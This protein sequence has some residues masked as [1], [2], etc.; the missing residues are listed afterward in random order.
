MKYTFVY[1]FIAVAAG[2]SISDLPTCATSCLIT[3]AT[4]VGCGLTDFA[5]ACRKSSE[6]TP[7]LTTCVQ[8]DCPSTE[9]QQKVVSVVSALCSQA[10]VP[11]NA[12]SSSSV[13]SSASSRTTASSTSLTYLPPNLSLS[14]TSVVSVPTATSS[15]SANTGGGSGGSSRSSTGSGAT[16]AGSGGGLGGA[17][18]SAGGSCVAATVTVTA[19]VPGVSSGASSGAA[20]SP[21]FPTTGS[22][23]VSSRLSSVVPSGSRVSSSLPPSFTGSAQGLKAP[24]LAGIF[25]LA[26]AAL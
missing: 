26:V 17:S 14:G 12:G 6:L 8:G 5:C 3:G 15:G 25:G 22:S 4:N 1:A 24:M 20:S 2:Q 16:S 9:D 18:G 10:G 19:G 7:A 23:G 13:S 11:I 21:R